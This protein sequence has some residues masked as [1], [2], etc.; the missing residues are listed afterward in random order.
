MRTAARRVVGISAWLLA[1]AAARAEC[2]TLVP[3]SHQ[4]GG[5]FVCEDFQD[6]FQVT[7][8]AWVLSDPAGANSGAV[9]IDCQAEEEQPGCLGSGIY[10]DRRLSISSD[11]SAPGMAGCPVADGLPRRLVLVVSQGTTQGHAIETAAAPPPDPSPEL[12]IPPPPIGRAVIVSLAGIADFGYLVEGAHPF[13][14]GEVLPLECRE[15]V[16]VVSQEPVTGEVTVVFSPPLIHTDCDA[17]SV[18]EAASLCTDAF[19]PDVRWGPVYT[20]RQSCTRRVDPRRTGWQS[21]GLVP[22]PDGSVRLPVGDLPGTDCL[23]VG[24]TTRI[25]G[26]ETELI[27]GFAYVPNPSFC[28]DGDGDGFSICLADCDDSDPAINPGAAE[29]CNGRDDDCDGSIDEGFDPD[30]DGFA[31]CRD[32]CPGTANPG[33]EDADGDGVG[34]ACDNCLFD[35]NA[36]QMDRDA[37]GRGDACDNCRDVPNPDQSDLD[38]DGLGDAC[39]PC[40]T[41]PNPS[42][43]PGDCQCP[44]S[45]ITISFRGPEGRGSG[46]V[47][48]RTCFELNLRGF[49]IVM[50]TSQGERAQL[51]D[52][53]I[54]CIECVTGQGAF[55]SHIIPRHKSGRSIFVEMVRLDG[56]IL[57][58]GPAIRID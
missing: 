56:V 37:D 47:T 54:P 48:W 19:A 16:Q 2:P 20:L 34:D 1:V 25:D 4:F 33:Q 55:Y 57:V 9:D 35:A 39:D 58:F 15:T 17:G 27:T 38:F 40:P 42:G 28:P 23:Y 11:W 6:N 29:V 36:D 32:N 24:G 44:P 51:N 22:G 50:L 21:T 45:Q 46:V 14:E 8:Y 10:G 13:R 5:Y 3:L 53:L 43:D 7:S 41:I 12:H 26:A 18:G 31:D 30:G 52:V 49:N